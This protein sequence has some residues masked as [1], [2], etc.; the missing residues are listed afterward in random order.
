MLHICFFKE[1][2]FYCHKLKLVV[3]VDGSVHFEKEV[4]EADAERQRQ[5]EL[6]WLRAIRFTNEEVL[7]KKEIVTEE[8]NL[9]I[10]QLVKPA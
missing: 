10:N 7:K 4:R 3:E 8:I 9:L 5:L 1:V 6:D 2:D